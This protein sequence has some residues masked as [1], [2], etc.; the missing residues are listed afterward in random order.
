MKKSLFLL[1]SLL[2][3]VGV[4]AWCNLQQQNPRPEVNPAITE[5]TENAT[6]NVT[7]SSSGSLDDLRAELWKNSDEVVL[8]AG[9]YYTMDEGI[10]GYYF[11]TI[12][13]VEDNY[14]NYLILKQK[15][16]VWKRVWQG[17]NWV[18]SEDCE[19]IEK[20]DPAVLRWW[21]LWSYCWSP[22]GVKIFFSQ[23]IQPL[24]SEIS[25][26]LSTIRETEMTRKP[27]DLVTP[28]EKA[29]KLIVENI[30]FQKAETIEK[31]FLDNDW[32]L[33]AEFDYAKW[34]FTWNKGFRKDPVICSCA[35]I[36]D[37]GENWN[38]ELMCSGI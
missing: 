12:T 33:Y 32:E 36:S 35:M 20:E 24:F 31:L 2:L 14:P 34:K 37:D 9:E 27:A 29:Y 21:E 13:T 6:E 28:K 10:D 16:G 1:M 19:R 25:F 18:S 26:D 3:L 38:L 8:G 30:A 7:I 22:M 17:M 15:N 23:E 5:W 11:F 4:L